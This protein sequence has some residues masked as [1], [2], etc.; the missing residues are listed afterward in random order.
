M[1]ADPFEAVASSDARGVDLA[2]SVMVSVAPRA[3]TRR[4]YVLSTSLGLE[5]DELESAVAATWPDEGRRSVEAESLA[6][7]PAIERRGRTWHANDAVVDLLASHF[8]GQEPEAFGRL[9][10]RL[11][12]TEIDTRDSLVSEL[13]DRG[14]V[15]AWRS[16]ARV[17]FYRAATSPERSV[18]EFGEAFSEA[19]SPDVSAYRLWVANLVKRREPLLMGFPRELAFYR[20][21]RAYI[22]GD[23]RKAA[24][25][26]RAVVRDAGS[27]DRYRAI[28]L[29][30]LAV[31]SGARSLSS[32][33]RLEES[34]SLS[35]EMGLVENE[36][37]ARNSLV[38]SLVKR[39]EARART[40]G[41]NRY[42]EA[43]SVASANLELAGELGPPYVSAAERAYWTVKWLSATDGRRRDL[44]AAKSSEANEFA[45]NLIRIGRDSAQADG[46]TSILAFNDAASVWRDVG[47]Y[48]RAVEVI[49]E[50]V[51]RFANGYWPSLGR[52]AKTSASILARS[53]DPEVRA[54]CRR[55][56]RMLPG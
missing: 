51:E 54:I 13:R 43:L 55:V 6:L 26:F 39:A 30:L 12:R 15:E 10:S 48:T 19:P 21:F 35:V 52:V 47:S 28:S 18:K 8:S 37:M 14:E 3:V 50:V 44:S 17:A 53:D 11:M 41:S 45:H 9:N 49:V 5:F 34:V 36:V 33:Q 22:G 4:A 24:N 25:E 38:W 46:E 16:G 23:R 20:G 42:L 29:H 32:Q 27:M 56:L 31:I 40:V 1:I 7:W 2:V